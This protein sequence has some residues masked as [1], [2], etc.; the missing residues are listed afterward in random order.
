MRR[1][2]RLEIITEAIER[3]IPGSTP[4]FLSVKVTETFPQATEPRENSWT[5]SPAALAEHVFTRLYGRPDTTPAA[6]PLAQADD[7]KRRRDI[8]GEVGALMAA[9]TDLESAPWYPVRPGDLVHV[10]YEAAGQA[11]A[12]GETYI[13]G[14]EDGGLMGMKLLTHTLPDAPK[15]GGGMAGWFAVEAADCPIYELWF[16]AG[17]HRLTIIRDGRPVHIGGAR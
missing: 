13:V 2:T 17:Q 9:G 11:S 16:E 5:G 7:A 15:D 6:S 8:V 3:L 14:P 1:D 10:N 4:A 12:F